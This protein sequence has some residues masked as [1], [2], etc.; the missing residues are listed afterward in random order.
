MPQGTKPQPPANSIRVACSGDLAGQPYAN[1]FH[2]QVPANSFIDAGQLTTWLG[3]FEESFNTANLLANFSTTLHVTHMEAIFFGGSGF[4]LRSDRTVVHNGGNAGQ[5]L[6]AAMCVCSSWLSSAYWRGGKP[7]TY[8]GGVPLSGVDTNHS[9]LDTYKNG[10]RS[11]FENWLNAVN[12]ITTPQV[13]ETHLGFVHFQ[14][15]DVWLSP[16][17]FIRFTG[18]T[19]HDR[20]AVQRR[21]LGP[22][23]V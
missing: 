21:R 13:P 11:T 6:S 17:S 9:L 7:R 23:V 3:F 5:A 2:C 19:V 1:V 15:G 12:S 16:P 14:S 8:W 22:W 20:L 18:V 4:H 10:L